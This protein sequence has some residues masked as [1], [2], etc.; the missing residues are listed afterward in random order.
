MALLVTCSSQVQSYLSLPADTKTDNKLF[1]LQEAEGL[2]VC[3]NSSPTVHPC[4]LSSDETLRESTLVQGP[5]YKQS[6]GTNTD[7]MG[8]GYRLDFLLWFFLGCNF[9][10]ATQLLY[11]PII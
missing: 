1:T 8:G 11:F 9:I 2:T 6:T 3:E 5:L 4:Q 7:V 10:L